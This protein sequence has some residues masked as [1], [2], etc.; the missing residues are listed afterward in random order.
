MK[1][2][3]HEKPNSACLAFLLMFLGPAAPPMFRQQVKTSASNATAVSPA[4]W[5]SR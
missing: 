3:T 4:G 2:R 5:G 1:P